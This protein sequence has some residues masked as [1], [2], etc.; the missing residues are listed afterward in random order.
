[1][2]V[3]GPPPPPP[4]PPPPSGDAAQVGRWSQPVELGLV[5]VNMVYMH[6]GKVLMY[7]GEGRDETHPSVWDPVTGT[8]KAVP[9]P[10]NVFC[11]GHSQLADGRILVVG[12]HGPSGAADAGSDQAAIFD[13]VSETW[14][15]VPRMSQ[16]RWYPT[17]TTL[18]DGRVLV[19]SGS[20]NGP[21]D[22]ADIPEIYDPATNRWTLLTEARLSHWYYPFSFLLPDGKVLIAGS[23]EYPTA[24]WTLDVAERRWTMVD[25]RLI[26]GGSAV[27]YRPG[28]VLKSGTA[29]KGGSAPSA[30]A[31]VLD[32][33]QTGPTWQPAAPMA[34]PRAFHTL[35]MLPTGDVIVTGGGT[36]GSATR[37][38]DAVYEAE[39]WSPGTNTWK[40][41]AR[42]SVPRL[43]HGTA[44]L[45]RDGRVVVAG[46]GSYGPIADETTAEFFEPPYL[47]QGGARP[48]LTGAPGF[49][50]HGQSF[51]ATTSGTI[52]SVALVR[53]GAVTHAFD[54]D[55]RY[56][57]L[58][59]TQTGDR[60]DVTAPA[61]ANLAPPG[62]YLLYAVDDRGVP[63]VGQWVRLPAVGADTTPPA[64]S[65]TSPASGSTVSGSVTLSADASDDVAVGSVQFRVDG[66]A[67]GAADT[68]APYSV[69]WS[70]G[71]VANGSHTVTAV[72]RDVAGNTTT[73]GA[74]TVTVANTAP[75]PPPDLVG[76]WSFDEG[77][78]NVAADRSG[79]GN[80]GTVSGASW[81]TA[82][83]NGGALSFDGVNDRVVVADA[84]SLDLT[85]R[86]TLE[87]WVRPSTSTA[88]WRTVLLKEHS[89]GLSYSLYSANGAQARPNAHLN[90]GGDKGVTAPSGIPVDTWSHL[91]V[92]FDGA[93]ARLYVN[94][95]QVA[96][97]AM[98][99]S[100]ATGSGVLSM[101]GN[102]VWGEWFAGRL[103][104]V[105]IYSAVRSAAQIQEDMTRPVG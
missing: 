76:A 24:T 98:S 44:L 86:M 101:G 46:S 71:T 96:T 84:A 48:T 9:A 38:S 12:G 51:T 70:S 74:V 55:T 28:K 35:S 58:A 52:R 13:P 37:D 63:A 10:Y 88:A 33:T 5:A 49:V 57:P 43:Y 79:I 104:D 89:S 14:T 83:K 99:G 8:I 47:H 31:H 18:P 15:S 29:W 4:P 7:T 68:T 64:V 87:A 67:V 77:S 85:N 105:R 94:G 25:D 20:K 81:T 16:A 50:E 59:F 95:A 2:M 39:I 23:D 54:E 73:S 75:P 65:V 42:A 32:M 40:T 26:D 3:T 69:A 66:Q 92:T 62:Y 90:V 27:M 103:D 100:M 56:V 82:G 22:I 36:S 97:R 11:S 1:M 34:F 102:G 78:G 80:T 21:G 30:A 91:A 41:M 19:T 45:L 60:L 61:N 72:A 17:A 93:T 53:P 6:T